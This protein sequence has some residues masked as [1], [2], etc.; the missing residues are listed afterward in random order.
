L[1]LQENLARSLAKRSS[2]KAG[3]ILQREEMEAL[4]NNLFACST[5]TYTPDG[6][7]TFHVM[8]LNRIEQY[9]K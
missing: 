1:P 5:S 6:R 2:I 9:F 3:Q 4:V 8:E 7:T